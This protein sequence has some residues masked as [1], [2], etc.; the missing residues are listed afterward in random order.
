[1]EVDRESPRLLAAAQEKCRHLLHT[2]RNLLVFPEGTRARSGRLQPF[3]TLAFR[4]AVDC[5]APVV[6]VIVHSTSPFMARI[7]GSM[8]P[9][10]PLVYRIRFLEPET[11]EPGETAEGLCDRIRRRMARELRDLDRGTV[12]AAEGGTES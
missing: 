7:P 9:R 8:F 1:V 10:R 2:D 6:P 12:W 11:A 3:H 5:R 4:V